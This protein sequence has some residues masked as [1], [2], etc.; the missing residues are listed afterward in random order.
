MPELPPIIDKKPTDARRAYVPRVNQ[1][2]NFCG[3]DKDNPRLDLVRPAASNLPKILRKL[4]ERLDEYYANPKKKW[5]SLSFC[6]GSKR[7][8]RSERREG[9][10][11]MLKAIVKFLDL[12]TMCVVIPNYKDEKY[13]APTLSTLA[14]HSGLSIS[15]AERALADLR[16]DGVITGGQPRMRQADGSYKGLPAVRAVSRHLFGLFGL[17]KSLKWAREKATAKFRKIMREGVRSGIKL[18]PNAMAR[19]SLMAKSP[20][21]FVENPSFTP[22]ELSPA[23]KRRS[24]DT[25]YAPPPLPTSLT[26]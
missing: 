15:R 12:R 11:L 18:S 22:P 20:P 8:Q 3:H 6:N 25:A 21:T 19:I 16:K 10:V 26:F 14:K 7:M 17:D 5:P 1:G 9:C 24:D 23:E 2:G 13:G 4:T